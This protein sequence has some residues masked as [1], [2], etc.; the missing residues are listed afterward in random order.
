MTNAD[1]LRSLDDY[2]LAELFKD[3]FCPMKIAPYEAEWWVC[4][5]NCLACWYHWLTTEAPGEK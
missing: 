2:E 5:G 3:C 4:E 1:K